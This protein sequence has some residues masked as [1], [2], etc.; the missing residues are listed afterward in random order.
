MGHG[1]RASFWTRWPDE[2]EGP[3]W[4]GIHVDERAGVAAV[5]GV[6]LFSEAPAT[7]RTSLGPPDNGASDLFPAAPAALRKADVRSLALTTLLERFRASGAA[8]RGVVGE[9]GERTSRYTADH[10]RRVATCYRVHCS[11][12]GTSRGVVDAVA[13]RWSVSRATAKKW[14]ARARSEGLL[15]EA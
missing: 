10:W 13:G 3:L 4:A 8:A 9:P 5:V 1:R 7:A 2:V 14:I 11:R 6:E 15:D 12:S